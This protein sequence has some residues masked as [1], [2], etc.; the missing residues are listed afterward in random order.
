MNFRTG[1]CH[2]AALKTDKVL[3]LSRLRQSVC[4]HARISLNRTKHDQHY[5]EFTKPRPVLG[6]L[7]CFSLEFPCLEELYRP[8][9]QPPNYEWGTLS[10]GESWVSTCKMRGPDKST[11]DPLCFQHPISQYLGAESTHDPLGRDQTRWRKAKVAALFFAAKCQ[12]I[13]ANFNWKC[14]KGI[15]SSLRTHP[16]TSRHV[17]THFFQDGERLLMGI[18]G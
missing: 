18:E 7:E 6:L 3:T 13:N 8:P 17:N 2:G 10:L 9:A 16:G 4:E 5:C 12:L 1:L 15:W 14:L 11:S